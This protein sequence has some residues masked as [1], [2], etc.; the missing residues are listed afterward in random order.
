MLVR[1]RIAAAEAVYK[2]SLQKEEFLGGGT[3]GSLIEQR[4]LEDESLSRRVASAKIE[5]EKAAE[6]YERN[7]ALVSAGERKR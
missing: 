4:R 2:R 7:F 5:S 3:R 1:A 6:V